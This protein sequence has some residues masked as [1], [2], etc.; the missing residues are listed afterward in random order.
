MVEARGYVGSSFGEYLREQGTLTETTASAVKRVV[1]WRERRE[2]MWSSSGGY[3]RHQEASSTLCDGHGDMDELHNL[4]SNTVS[5]YQDGRCVTNSIG[6]IVEHCLT[7]LERADLTPLG[8][9]DGKDYHVFADSERLS[10]PVHLPLLINDAQSFAEAWSALHGSARPGERR[11]DYA[12]GAIN[13]VFYTASTAFG[14]CYDVWKPGSRK[15]PGTFFEVLLGSVL[16]VVLP[17]FSRTSQIVLPGQTRRLATDIVFSK[18]GLTG[19]L[20]I[21]AKITTRERIVQPFAH[22]RILDSVFGEGRFRSVLVCVS[23]MQRQGHTG[24]N[25]ICVPG[26][27]RLYQQHLAPLSGLYYMD[28]PARYMQD[29]VVEHLNVDNLGALLARDLPTLVA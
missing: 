15:T 28:P 22:Q 19:G 5:A 11:Y 21:P 27:V 29:D 9:C 3:D 14:A 18:P 25:A 7:L 17:D 20:V 10:R 8:P 4:Q 2:S 16:E 23:E 12:P 6:Q 26:A 13:K 24:A 1:A